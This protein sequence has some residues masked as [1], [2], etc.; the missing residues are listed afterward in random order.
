LKE[1]FTSG[2]TLIYVCRDGICQLPVEDLKKAMEMM[3]EII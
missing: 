3:G 1:R 2:K